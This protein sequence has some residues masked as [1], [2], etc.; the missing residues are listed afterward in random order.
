M[1]SQHAEPT[2]VL[3]EKPTICLSRE[4]NH[5]THSHWLQPIAPSVNRSSMSLEVRTHPLKGRG[6]Y[7]TR[8]IRAGEIVLDEA[9]LLLTVA[10]EHSQSSCANCLRQI[11]DRQGE[12]SVRRRRHALK[13][14]MG[15]RDIPA[16][17]R[18]QLAL[19]L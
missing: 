1:L 16:P 7:T 5:P 14:C 8:L 11:V 19:P 15:N 18:Q 6:L 13:T 9:P 2:F 17:A 3:A 4:A 12:R 10:P